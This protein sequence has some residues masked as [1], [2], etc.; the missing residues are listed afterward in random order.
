MTALAEWLKQIIIV[1]LLATFI[2]LILP[3]RSLQRYVKLVVSLFIIIT[4]LSPILHLLGTSMNFQT[5]TAFVDNKLIPAGGSQQ[6]GSMADLSAILSDG[7]AI[8]AEQQAQSTELLSQRI[9]ERVREQVRHHTNTEP[10]A[11]NVKL[12][13]TEQETPVIQLIRI[14]MA[15]S[16]LPENR[17]ILQ[18]QEQSSVQIQPIKI[19]PVEID[20]EIGESQSAPTI[21]AK[22]SQHAIELQNVIAKS[23]GMDSNQIQIEWVERR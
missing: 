14:R 7:A 18:D 15:A 21:S 6:A 22:P 9:A 8:Q 10:I 12:R 11:V 1:V 5:M 23:W 2:D 3:N 13:A 16:S 4:I 19:E 17:P 20:V